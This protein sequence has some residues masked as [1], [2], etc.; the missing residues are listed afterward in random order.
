MGLG[1]FLES[2][3]FNAEK[4]GGE[5]RKDRQKRERE[6]GRKRE[7]MKGEEARMGRRHKGKTVKS[8]RDSV[9]FCM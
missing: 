6:I 2:E 1:T 7:L 3:M 9:K 5:E 8:G 4:N